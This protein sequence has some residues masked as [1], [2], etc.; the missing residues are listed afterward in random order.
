VRVARI[1]IIDDD[2]PLREM[3]L[4]ALAEA[5]HTAVGAANG[6]DAVKL[7]RANPADLIVTDIM[8]PYDGLSMIRILHGE[9][10]QLGIIAMSGGGPHRLDYARSLGAHR[11]LT[12]P[13]T[14]QELTLAIAEVLAA[15]NPPKPDA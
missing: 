4:D 8:M 6:L 9:F 2:K 12:K 3:L 1:L 5:G 15:Q 14:T 10:P 13:F 11:T 7:F